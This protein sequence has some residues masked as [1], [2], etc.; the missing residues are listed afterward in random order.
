MWSKG[1]HGDIRLIAK[2]LVVKDL[3]EECIRRRRRRRNNGSVAGSRASVQ[4]VI[5]SISDMAGQGTAAGNRTASKNDGEAESP[6]FTS[7]KRSKLLLS[8]SKGSGETE[9][10]QRSHWAQRT[11]PEQDQKRPRRSC[12][13]R[14]SRRWQ[15]ARRT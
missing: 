4:A 3:L 8:S 11:C 10:D 13:H 9:L 2:T 6:S 12:P 14:R 1:I 7:S 15:Q 5:R